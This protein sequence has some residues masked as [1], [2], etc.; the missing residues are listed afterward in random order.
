M[1]YTT[2]SKMEAKYM[3]TSHSRAW[4]CKSFIYGFL[5]FR[6]TEHM[7]IRLQSCIIYCFPII[8]KLIEMSSYKYVI[9]LFPKWK[10]NTWKLVIQEHGNASLSYMYFWYFE[11]QSIWTW[12]YRAIHHISQLGIQIYS[13]KR[14][15]HSN[16]CALN[17]RLW[18]NGERRNERIGEYMRIWLY[19]PST[20]K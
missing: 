20:C 19:G 16:K 4:E 10:P 18:G 2:L 7:E 6:I 1:L 9:Q 14:K 17:M 15:H 5:I 12:D 13:A 11:L 8:I 3:K